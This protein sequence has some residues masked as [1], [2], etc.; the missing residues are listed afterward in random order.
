MSGLATVASPEALCTAFRCGM[1]GFKFPGF[2]GNR[3][4]TKKR[5]DAAVRPKQQWLWEVPRTTGRHKG[6]AKD[7]F[8]RVYVAAIFGVRDFSY[9]VQH[10]SFA[11]RTA[12]LVCIRRKYVVR[13]GCGYDMWRK[14]ALYIIRSTKNAIRKPRQSLI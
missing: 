6:S 8:L 5:E 7:N 2:Y 9:S 13:P 3:F 10:F 12:F 11:W 4:S 1:Q 14:Q